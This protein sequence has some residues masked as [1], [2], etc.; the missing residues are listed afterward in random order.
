M[1]TEHNAKTVASELTAHLAAALKTTVA[2]DHDLFASGLVSSMFAMQ[3]VVH[4]EGT[5]GVA[6][7]GGDLKLDNFRT[8]DR[9]TELVLRLR[10]AEPVSDRA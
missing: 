10:Q 8:V 9:M 4:L 5:Y 3:L 2:P 6:I 7:V 1:S